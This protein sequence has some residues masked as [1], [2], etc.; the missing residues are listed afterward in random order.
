LV[1][2]GELLVGALVAIF[3]MSSQLLPAANRLALTNIRLQEARVAF[4][5]MHE[6]TSLEPEYSSNSEHEDNFFSKIESL[7]VKGVSFRFPGHSQ[8]LKN[9]SFSL[10]RG[11]MIALLGE[12]GCGKTTMLQ[13]LQRFYEPEE[14]R[15][16]MN[17]NL[18][19][20]SLSVKSWR[21]NIASVPQSIKIF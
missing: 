3:Q 6:F 20:Q 2:R 21:S 9:I 15:I 11:E 14:G 13:I 1:L 12:S 5:R 4:D 18:D 8:L 17:G 16:R 10:K 7:S 19:L